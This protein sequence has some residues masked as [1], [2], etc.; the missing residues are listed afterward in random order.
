MTGYSRSDVE[1]R[2]LTLRTLTPP[3][4][5][6]ASEEQLKQLEATGRIGPYEKEYL[7]KDGSHSWMLLAGADLGDGTLVT[8]CLD[9]VDRKRTEEE[10]E[11]LVRE[12]SHRVKNILA[13]VQSLA[14]QTDGRI[15]SVDAFREAFL[16]RLRALARAH[17]VLLNAHWRSADLRTLIE[18][19]VAAG[20]IIRRW[21]RS[22]TS[23]SP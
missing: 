20:W 7:C 11:L 21:S 18:E 5:I 22:R 14:T 4:W 15:G 12:L 1:A 2:R 19:A 9:I 10:R 6:E 13:M 17:S 3:E 8:Y 23:A 16:G